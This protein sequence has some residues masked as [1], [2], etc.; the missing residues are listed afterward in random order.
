[1][2]RTISFKRV[3]RAGTIDFPYED[4]WEETVTEEV[5]L[6][7]THEIIADYINK[8][9][10]KKYGENKHIYLK[11][12]LDIIEYA[13]DDISDFVDYNEYFEEYLR[14]IAIQKWNEDNS[15]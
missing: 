1:M 15:K 13:Y 2:R 10:R 5:S 8:N 9:W 3:V 14:E 6:E 11:A 7:V 4:T 12:V